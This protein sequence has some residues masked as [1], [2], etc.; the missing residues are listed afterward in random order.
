[1]DQVWLLLAKAEFQDGNYLQAVSTF[2]YITKI[3]ST[4]P[5]IVA[6][7]QLWI[8]RAY[9]EMGWMYEAGDILHKI[10]IAGGPPK[11]IKVFMHW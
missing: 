10:E 7:C 9:T 11:S 2:L 1:M 4:N 3:Y 8:A 5:E 6:E